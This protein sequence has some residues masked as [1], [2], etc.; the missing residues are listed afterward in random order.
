MH[1][2]EGLPFWKPELDPTELNFVDVGNT[3]SPHG[4]LGKMVSEVISTSIP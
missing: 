2:V 3:D 4:T 1:L